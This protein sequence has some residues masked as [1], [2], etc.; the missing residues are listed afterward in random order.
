MMKQTRLLGLA[1]TFSLMAL[2]GCTSSPSRTVTGTAGANG[3]TAG[4][5]T[6][7]ANGSAGATGGTAGTSGSAGATGGTAGA[8]GG[9]GTAGA[10]GSAGATGGTAGASGSAGA[11]GSAGAGTDGGSN[12]DAIVAV[13]GPDQV[14]SSYTGRPL[15]GTPQTIP[16]TIQVENY[17]TGGPGVAYN[18][19]GTGHG[20]LCGVTRTDLVNLN[21]TGQNGSPTDQTEGTCAKLMGDVYLGYIDAG[22]W[23]NYTVTVL[24]AGTYA[25]STHAGVEGTPKLMFTF[26]PT[27]K[28]DALPLMGTSGCGVEDYH[29]WAVQSNVGTIA[30]TPGTYVMRLDFVAVGLNLDWVAFTK[31]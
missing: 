5:G 22:D 12:T 18:Y 29:V 14:P 24:E 7:G 19:G 2:V 15:G 3:G 11:T 31:M 17:D 26:T 1:G 9:A 10:N 4:A 6:A 20:S 23:L 30:L 16:G 13:D 27:V 8:N 28:T 25:I 21:C